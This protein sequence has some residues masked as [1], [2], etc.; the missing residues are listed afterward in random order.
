MKKYQKKQKKIQ[1]SAHR[2]LMQ[3]KRIVRLMHERVLLNKFDSNNDNVVMYNAIVNG[4]KNNNDKMREL[5][6][7][8]LD[9]TSKK[10]F[11][12]CKKFMMMNDIEELNEM[13]ADRLRV[14]T[15]MNLANDDY[16]RDRLRKKYKEMGEKCTEFYK[17]LNETEESRKL[18]KL[19]KLI[20]NVHLQC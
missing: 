2:R 8:E 14:K 18:F 20:G 15:E 11:T 1:T 5:S 7:E 10:V 4:V 17:K 13:E 16:T 6:Y 3:E 9:S 19:C 12:F